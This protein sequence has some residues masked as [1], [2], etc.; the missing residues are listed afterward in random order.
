M[1]EKRDLR[2]VIQF[3]DIH[4][5]NLGESFGCLGIQIDSRSNFL[6]AIKNGDFN[7]N[8]L[9][10]ITGDIAADC[11]SEEIY[12]WVQ[13]QVSPLPCKTIFIP[14]NHDCPALMKEN[15]TKE[16][17]PSEGAYGILNWNGWSLIFLD[18]SEGRLSAEQA[19][20]ILAQPT[21]DLP[22]LLFMH[23]PPIRCGSKWMDK[24]FPLKDRDEAWSL[25]K[26]IP[27]LKA[28]F[29]GHYHT[30][31]KVHR[32]GIDVFTSPTTTYQIYDDDSTSTKRR[33]EPVIGYRV[34]FLEEDRIRTETH[35]F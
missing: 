27:S 15:F 20:W 26:K 7:E 30:E 29:T 16:R 24:R 10:V 17:L 23:H 28:V 21:R 12:F 6:D 3:T 33:D 2:R 18:T 25:L 22:A 8:D 34:I 31:D 1:N 13:N 35:Y 19:E 5:P 32:D 14:G 9:L 11:G 4:I